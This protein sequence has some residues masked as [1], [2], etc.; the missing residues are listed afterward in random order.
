MGGFSQHKRLAGFFFLILFLLMAFSGWVVTSPAFRD[1]GDGRTLIERWN[2]GLSARVTSTVEAFRGRRS[3][4]KSTDKAK[5]VKPKEIT[6]PASVLILDNRNRPIRDVEVVFKETYTGK[7]TK[8]K[9]DSKGRVSTKL[10]LGNYRLSFSHGKYSREVREDRKILGPE[11]GF[12]ISV[13]LNTLVKVKGQV[14]NEEGKPVPGVAV[15]GQRNWLQQFAESGNVFL[16]DAAYPTVLT[17]KNGKFEMSDV[18]I[19]DN[20]FVARLGGYA[21][22]ESRLEVPA[23]G[24]TKELKLVLKRPSEIS[25]QVVNEEMAPVPGVKVT[26]VSYQPHGSNPQMLPAQGFVVSTDAEGKFSL[27]KLFSDGIYLLRFE[28]AAYAVMDMGNVSAGTS[29]LKLIL[30]RGGEISGAVSYLDRPTTAARTLVQAMAVISGTTITRTVM[31]RASGEY[32]FER[33]PYGSY[34]LSVDF[35]NFTNEPRGSVTSVKDRP[36]TGNLVEIYE[37]ALL[38]GRVVDAFSGDPL[39]EAEVFVRATYGFSKSRVRQLRRVTDASGNFTFDRLPGGTHQIMAKVD[40][41]LPA[42][43]NPQDYTIPIEPG[44]RRDD[45]EVFLSK[46]GIVKGQVITADGQG[47]GE[48]EVQ[49]YVASGSFSGLDVKNLN[50]TTDGTGF[51]ELSGFPIGQR[52]TLYASA[53][54]EGFAKN[55][56]DLIELSPQQPEMLTQVILTQGGVVSGRITDT[57]GN[58]IYGVK[59]TFDSREFPQDPS[60]SEFY[61]F[62]DAD[63][64]YLLERCTQGRAVLVADHEKFVRQNKGVTIPEGRLL[65]RQ[66]FKLQRSQFIRGTVADF[67]GNPI[68]DARVVAAPVPKA[69]GN[70]RDTTDKKGEFHLEGM[71]PG[72]FRLEASFNLDTPDGKQ[73]YTFILPDI[74]AGSIGVPLDCDVAPTAFGSVRAEKGAKVDNFTITLRSRLDTNPKQLFRFNLTRKYASANGEFR[75]LQVPRGLYELKVEALGYQTWENEEIVIGPGNRT[76]LPTIRLKSASGITGTVISSTTGKPVQGALIRVLDDGKKEIETVNRVEL[77]GYQ[78]TD[79]LEYLNAAYDDDVKYDPDP[80]TR[81][82]ARVRANVVTTKETNV[83]GKFAVE[84]LGAGMYTVE[85]EHPSFRPKRMQSI[86]VNRDKN[87]DLGDVELEPGGI[88]RGRVVDLEGNGIPNADVRVKGEL[89]GRNRDR[90]DV[91]GNFTLRGIGYGEWPVSVL[92][93][94]NNRKI[95]AF[96]HVSVRPDETSLVEFVL[97]TTANVNGRIQLPGG[98]P[99]SGS[100][101]LYVVDETGTAMDDVVYSANLSNGTFKL[102]GIPPGRFFTIAYGVGPRGRFAFWTW[103]DVS[104]GRNQFNLSLATA[105]MAGVAA[106]VQDGTPVAGAQVQVNV[107]VSGVIVP[108]SIHNLLKVSDATDAA[109]KFQF[110]YLQQGT[111]RIWAGGPGQQVIPVDAIGV[112]NGQSIRGYTVAVRV[113]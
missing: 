54:K 92:A 79:I 35:D 89:Q 60:T 112:V 83:Y 15:T 38:T 48:A 70:G 69:T 20:S 42:S 13:I 49:L 40:G 50:V 17:D 109:G 106:N 78:R 30:Q 93:T 31:S 45:Y 21:T 113:P 24:L 66:N 80:L 111:Y 65:S 72:K 8:S 29:G 88:I 75:L 64:N 97:E 59:V 47:V 41:Y 37:K 87:T 103:L 33:L 90:T 110:P 19:G 96:K 34:K 107:D 84:D 56:S 67:K 26:A 76:N 57:D 94:L 104:R 10:P 61:T 36:S 6:G 55:H 85:V 39:P 27:K 108:A 32:K 43:G 14:V 46:G 18:S 51:F 9:S 86:S 62:T 2:D 1:N 105:S 11:N 4:K 99:R 58:P 77:A 102:N 28:N 63:G 100:V 101:R 7:T 25:G 82:V 98:A 53:R 73:S 52:L 95:Y 5:P 81:P 16:D 23:G 12:S 91:A 71:S 3:S 22:A 68:A 74:E 44:G